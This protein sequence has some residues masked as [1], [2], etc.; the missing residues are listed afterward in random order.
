MSTDRDRFECDLDNCDSNKLYFKYELNIDQKRRKNLRD[1]DV[2]EQSGEKKVLES[3]SKASKNMK[4]ELVY[5]FFELSFVQQSQVLSSL[6]LLRDEYDGK[7]YIDVIES[8][9]K[10]AQDKKLSLIH[11]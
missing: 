4:R 3:Q 10:D 2:K 9:L 6:D 1:I 7:R 8:I 11:I 5:W